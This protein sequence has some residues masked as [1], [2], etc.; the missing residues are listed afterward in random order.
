MQKTFGFIVAV[1]FMCFC[2]CG[3]TMTPVM[4]D[5]SAGKTDGV[6]SS[7]EQ[8]TDIEERLD[9]GQTPLMIA[10]FKGDKDTVAKLLDKGANIES[11]DNFGRTPLMFAVLGGD[12]PT[13]E[14]LLNRGAVI[15]I[16]DNYERTAHFLGSQTPHF[17]IVT[18]VLENH[19]DIK[20]TPFNLSI[21]DF[22]KKWKEVAKHKKDEWESPDAV[23]KK[24]YYRNVINKKLAVSTSSPGYSIS[25][26]TLGPYQ[27]KVY[28][29]SVSL[30]RLNELF[31]LFYLIDIDNLLKVVDPSLTEQERHKITT[32]LGIT[33]KK[34]NFSKRQDYVIVNGIV[35]SIE[36]GLR[37]GTYL[38]FTA[39][40]R[41]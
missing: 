21:I 18:K 41:Q 6:I 40:P 19:P 39:Y 1:C 37:E 4:K 25:I 28:W 38:H 8:G 3:T 32:D 29:A 22:Q 26:L 34:A 7:L 27:N 14:T 11:R 17:N 33:G 13:I 2:G 5:S 36:I 35:Y 15:N 12:G 23:N 16:K 30:M 24:P 9:T 20:V 10:A 31:M